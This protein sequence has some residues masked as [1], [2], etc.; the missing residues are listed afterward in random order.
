MNKKFKQLYKNEERNDKPMDEM[1][2]GGTYG[3]EKN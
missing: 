1:F 3:Q 2:E